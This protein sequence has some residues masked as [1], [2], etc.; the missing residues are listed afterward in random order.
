MVEGEGFASINLNNETLQNNYNYINKNFVITKNSTNNC[1]NECIFNISIYLNKTKESKYK[2][3]IYSIVK[4]DNYHFIAPEL[5]YIYG[6]L[7]KYGDFDSH[8]T[9]ITKNTQNLA[10]FI[11]CNNCSLTIENSGETKIILIKEQIF[12][13]LNYTNDEE[14][15]I[16]YKIFNNMNC[17]QNYNFRIISF[18]GNNLLIP[19]NSIRNEY[20]KIINKC[21]FFIIKEQYNKIK[22]IRLL[23][24]NS[25]E[26]NINIIK[27]EEENGFYNKETMDV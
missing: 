26:L 1:K 6:N 2:Y 15:E 23:T 19:M 27:I 12:V 24:P 7:E 25:N 16:Y 11:N 8:R 21:Q 3:N 9:K 20:C 18:Y 17:N 5:E 22:K 14:R 4:R 13:N 10:F